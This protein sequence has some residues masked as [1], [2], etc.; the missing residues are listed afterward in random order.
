MEAEPTPR[1]SGAPAAVYAERYAG[2]LAEERRLA[3][4]SL[5]LSIARGVTFGCFLACLLLVLI[6]ASRPLRLPLAGAA[7]ALAVF[8]ALALVHDR[9][10]RRLRRAEELR[11]I[12]GEGLARLDRDWER[13][14]LPS[15]PPRDRSLPLARDL[16]L[17]G[18]ASLFHLLGTAHTPAAKATLRDWLEGE[19]APAEVRAR[20]AAVAELAEL[21]DFRQLLE[22][23]VRGMEAGGERA[24][25]PDVEPFLRWAEG[26]P[27]LLARPALL[28]AARAAAV[29]TIAAFALALAPGAPISPLLAMVVLNLGL[30]YACR[31]ELGAGLGRVSATRDEMMRYA[32]A[33]RQA[34]SQPFAAPRLAELAAALQVTTAPDR[35]GTTPSAHAALATLESRLG[36]ADARHS[37]PVHFL[38]QVLTLWDFHVLASL[39]G[40]QRT[41]GRR[42]RRWLMALGEIEALAAL[43]ALRFENPGWC[44]PEVAAGQPELT[45]RDLGHPLLPAARRVG[46]DVTVGPAGT[47]LLVT[48]S[49]MSGKSTLL[50]AIGINA[51][52]AQAGGPACAASLRLPPVRLATS[53]LVEDSLAG[54]VSFFLAELLRIKK[55]VAGAPEAEARGAVLLYLLD[56]VLR[57]TN[58][59]ERQIAV[60][61]VLRHLLARGALGAVSTHDLDLA[62]GA[63]I[64]EAARPVHFRETLTPGPDGPRMTFDYRLRPGPATSTNALELLRQVGLDLPED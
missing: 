9:C 53:I 41:A 52:L 38:L 29:L 26:D 27:W 3:A 59:A 58:S 20:Q 46:N 10:L 25:P 7:A 35:R 18:R 61:R 32:A 37:A 63:G 33:L 34:A 24:G 40:W 62:A 21:L 64:A 23:T 54:G 50:R 48:G 60:R 19:A 51:V 16:D 17:Y 31:A 56:E 1:A 43:A 13:L 4:I 22:L 57:G 5:R 47:F 11:R 2:C 8:A 49:N 45:A 12:A 14:P 39:E 42:A 55:V 30:T 36:L 6:A 15:E 44:L 28:W